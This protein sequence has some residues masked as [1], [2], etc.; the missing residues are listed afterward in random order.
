MNYHFVFRIHLLF[1]VFLISC[2]KKA[3]FLIKANEVTP[4]CIIGFDSKDRTPNE[5]ITMIKEMGFKQYGYNK[6]KGNLNEMKEEFRLARNNNIKITSI[7][8]WLNAERDTIGKLSPSNQELLRNLKDLKTKP[9]IWLSF[10]NNF[11]EKLNQEESIELS[12]KMIKFVKMKADDLGCTLALYNHHGW[13][14]NPY[15][16]IKI[17]Q[18]LDEDNVTMVYNFH[19]A[20]EYVEEFPAIV[21]KMKPYLSF[22][23]LSGVKKEG[24]Q[25]LS[26]GEGDY[27]FK[28]IQQ[29]LNHGYVG[30]WGILGHIET[31]DVQMVLKKNVDGLELI[32]SKLQI[33]KIK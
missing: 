1:L 21:K 14:G 7:F 12:L 18:K 24:P 5:R 23:N 4:W 3:N 28:M 9:A 8:L 17:L 2:T 20:H 6:G 25:I 22:V 32:N 13:F 27:E 19:H 31:E 15:N 10:S 11:F 33:E 30:P 16:Q 29:L 26:I